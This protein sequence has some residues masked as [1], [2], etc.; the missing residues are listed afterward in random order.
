MNPQDWSA[1]EIEALARDYFAMLD[2]ELAGANYSKTAHRCLLALQLNGRSR[3]S[4]ESRHQMISA[5]LARHG[6]RRIRGYMPKW[7]VP[8]AIERAVLEYLQAAPELETRL[9]APL[10]SNRDSDRFT[11]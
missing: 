10:D 4:I 3:R 1:V 6:Y 9:R 7:K 8:P 11:A 5:V 2:A